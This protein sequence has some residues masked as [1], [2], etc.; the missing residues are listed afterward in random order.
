MNFE[1]MKLFFAKY[2]I[3]KII[4]IIIYICAISYG[5]YWLYS[6][7]LSDTVKGVIGTIL[8]AVVGGSFT[9]LGSLIINTHVQKAANAIRRKN[10]IYKPLYDEL[11]IIHN[12]ILKENPYPN[13]IEFQKGSQT[14]LKHPQYTV[15]GRI[16]N[17]T[18]YLEVPS[19]LKDAME[20]LYA[21][22]DL[23]IEKRKNAVVALDK[24]YKDSFKKITKLDIVRRIN[25][26]NSILSDIL[27]G[28]RT[29]TSLF[30]WSDRGFSLDEEELLW[31]ELIKM[32][33]INDELKQCKEA[34]VAWNMA[35]EHALKILGTY[36]QYIIAK[37]EE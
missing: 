28:N 37:Y 25:I 6:S 22:I 18:R 23:Y 15:W 17:D 19:K 4:F 30:S 27:Q 20:S 8:G 24:I 36:I 32:A 21:S 7:S 5:F 14:I 26:G 33:R 35:E 29:Q 16:K 1:K 34:K 13:F 2:K 11:T 9:L 10:V 12:E 3:V 31:N